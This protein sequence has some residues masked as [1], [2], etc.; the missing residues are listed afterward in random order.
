M[1]EDGA[2]MQFSVSQMGKGWVS[3]AAEAEKG[4]RGD[5][6]QCT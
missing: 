4:P 1:R 6:S 5:A 2:G 3:V